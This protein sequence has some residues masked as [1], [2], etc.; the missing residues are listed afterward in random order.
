MKYLFDG[1]HSDTLTVSGL[2][3]LM[4]R[5]INRTSL[6]LKIIIILH[7]TKGSINMDSPEDENI[8]TMKE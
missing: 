4:N 7:C 6:I 8:P 5:T 1:H 3:R 2:L